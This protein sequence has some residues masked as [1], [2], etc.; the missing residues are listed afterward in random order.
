VLAV[1]AFLHAVEQ[2]LRDRGE[3]RLLSLVDGKPLPVSSVSKDPDAR[4]GRGAG[5]MAKGYQLHT[6]R[7]GAPSAGR[8]RG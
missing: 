5:G 1:G 7:R 4:R 2:R 3:Q 6:R 8:W